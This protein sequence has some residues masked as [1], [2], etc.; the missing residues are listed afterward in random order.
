MSLLCVNSG[1]GPERRI[2]LR[3]TTVIGRADDSDLFF[4]DRALSRRHAEIQRRADG[5]FLVD[6]GSTNGTYLNGKRVWQTERLKSGDVIRV[7]ENVMTFEETEPEPVTEAFELVGA[8]IFDINDLAAR[9]TKPTLDV[10]ELVQQNQVLAVLSRA[11]GALVDH[12]ASDEVYD[13]IVNLLLESI[14]A[15]RAAVL[16]LDGDRARPI[17]KAS[18]SRGGAE[19]IRSVSM[20]IAQRVIEGQVALLLPDVLEDPVLRARESLAEVGIRTAMCA[21][22]WFTPRPGKPPKTLGLVY[23]D[24]RRPAGTFSETDLQILTV[25]ANVAAA[26]IETARLL[27]ESLEKR[28][29]EDDMRLAAEIQG[30]LLPRVPPD[31]PGYSVAGVTRSCRA[32]GGDYYDF[33]F[34]GQKLHFALGDVSGK[35]TGAAMLMTA[36][37]AAVRAQWLEEQLAEAMQ[38][39]NRTFHQVVP[40]DKYATFVLA[41]LD[42]GTGRLTY[43]NAGHNPPII[44]RASGGF[45]VLA[46]GGTIIGTFESSDFQESETE[47]AP[48]DTLVMFSDGISDNWSDLNV[49]DEQLVDIVRRRPDATAADLQQAIFDFVDSLGVARVNDDSTLVILRRL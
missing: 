34:D 21:P 3:E 15:E 27:E 45:E 35:G 14:P 28:R 37:K 24:S 11:T 46:V 9:A 5:Y 29:L 7:G 16:R 43:V 26:K 41:R 6:L 40:E 44:I 1:H 18:R 12:Y 38:R 25:L 30:T 39:I 42:P 2:P 13:R 49:A 10:G 8:Q 47:L 32:V 20:G 22:L 19:P 48:G 33:H 31:V 4:P 23:M 17:L 36:L